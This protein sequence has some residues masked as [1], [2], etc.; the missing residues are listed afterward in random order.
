MAARK[1]LDV[2]PALRTFM[3]AEALP[4]TGIAPARFWESMERILR[5][6]IPANAALLT[7][8]DS[9]QAQIDGWHRAHPARPLDRHEYATFLEEIGY[10]LPEP[11]RSR[12][13]APPRWTPR[14]A[15][16]RPAAGR[17]A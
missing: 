1:G 6:L 10:L 15:I 16:M 4:G 8:R 9:L 7:K 3:E 12:A 14:S 5:E 2:A 13:S 11:A 17:A